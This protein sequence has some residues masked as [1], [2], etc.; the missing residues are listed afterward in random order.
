VIPERIIFVSRGI[1]VTGYADDR[2]VQ[3]SFGIIIFY[4]QFTQVTS[5]LLYFH[6]KYSV[7]FTAKTATRPFLVI[8]LFLILR[9]LGQT[10][11]PHGLRRGSA[12]ERLQGW[13]V[14]IS[15]GTWVCVCVSLVSVACCEVEV[16]ATN[17]L[18]V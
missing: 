16:F 5:S 15:P 17:R 7:N 6:L 10:R 8:N 12:T 18:L 4:V 14:L 2:R 13:G 1:T 3:L 9:M 11:W